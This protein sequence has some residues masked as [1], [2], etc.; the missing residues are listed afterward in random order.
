MSINNKHSLFSPC[1]WATQ[2]AH[3]VWFLLYRHLEMAHMGGKEGSSHRP[4]FWAVTSFLSPPRLVV[5]RE[6]LR[7]GRLI[8]KRQKRETSLC[9]HP[10]SFPH[11]ARVGLLS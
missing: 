2:G 4:V 10:T 3:L 9:P 1:P 6:R 7:R 5:W 8:H 11:P